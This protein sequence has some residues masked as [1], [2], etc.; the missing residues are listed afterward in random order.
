M[1]KI[2]FIFFITMCSLA[3]E[4]YVVYQTDNIGRIQYHKD[5]YVIKSD[6]IYRRDSI[7]RTMEKVA[8]IPE[9]K[10]EEKKNFE[11]TKERKE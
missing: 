6:G 4:P 9:R 2:F 10:T 5:S 7:G 1:K 11:R 8:K 3:D